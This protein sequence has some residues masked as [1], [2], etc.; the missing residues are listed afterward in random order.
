MRYL[1]IIFI[2]LLCAVSLES[3]ISPGS[4]HR[5]IGNPSAGNGLS[6]TATYWWN[7]ADLTVNA[8]VTNWVDRNMGSAFVNTLGN[9]TVP[10]N[11]ANGVYFRKVSNQYLTNAGAVF[12]ATNQSCSHWVVVNRGTFNAWQNILDYTMDSMPYAIGFSANNK[13][14]AI[15][16]P[17]T[18]EGP[19]VLTNVWIDLLW[20]HHYPSNFLYFYTNGVIASGVSGEGQAVR[21][22][23]GVMGGTTGSGQWFEGYI[24]E[25]A[26]FSNKWVTTDE[27]MK[28]HTYATNKY[29]YTP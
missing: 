12:K 7:F 23:W 19:V 25:V 5:L 29:G 13:M 17:N 16:T 26:V 21:P 4:L 28:L 27:A 18:R 2:V 6:V 11:T 20:V 24:K 10:T 8:K 9:S 22:S 1:A 14:Y 3:Q 15:Q